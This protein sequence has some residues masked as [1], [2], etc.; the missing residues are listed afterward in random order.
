MNDLLTAKDVEVKVFKKARFGGYAVPEVE[1][2][3]NQV[4]DDLEAYAIQIDEKDARIA[5]L[6][7][8]VKKQDDMTDAIKDALIQARQ[9]AKEMEDKAQSER[10]A[11]IAEAKQ[12]AERIVSEAHATVQARIDEAERKAANLIAEARASASEATQASKDKRAKAEE[13]LAG[14][15]AEL[16]ARRK[17]AED[18]AQEILARARAESRTLVSDVK[19]E[20]AD[21]E[22]Q[23]QFLSLKK[24]QFLKD[25]VAMLLD[26]GK[27]IEDAQDEPAEAPEI[28]GLPD[29][30]YPEPPVPADDTEG[31]QE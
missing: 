25:A 14:I 24:Q 8:Y 6:E 7:A 16:S 15:E 18:E 28:E 19:K 4:A 17:S 13:A 2:F 26:F 5:E 9:A 22:K 1:D 23:I 20:A 30:S 29:D 21:Y 31:G 12:E 10:D 27:I 11:I 3:L